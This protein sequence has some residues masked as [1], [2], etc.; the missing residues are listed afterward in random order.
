MKK[1]NIIF[2]LLILILAAFPLVV[3]DQYF[4]HIGILILYTALIS[5]AWNILSGFSGQFSFGHAA[6]FGT[7]AYVSSILLT[8]FGITPWLG[9]FVGAIVAA[10]IGLFIGFLSFRYKLRGVFFALGTLAFA[11]I[12]RIIVQNFAFFNKTLGILIPLNPNPLMFQF[13][14]RV[15]YYYTILIFTLLVSLLVHWIS[16][17]RLGYNLIAIR[18]NEDAA[19]SL[20]VN[21]YKNKMIAIA[22]S[23]AVTAIGGTFYAQYILFIEPPTTFGNDV[24]INIILPTIIGGAGTVLGPIVGSFILIPIGE[25]TTALFGN[26]VG[27]N[28][29]A[30]G[31]ILILVILYLPEGIVGWFQSRF[32]KH[33]EKKKAT[34]ETQHFGGG[35]KVGTYKN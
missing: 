24:S 13:G 33:K 1:S 20:G 25:I 7:G 10:L 34:T 21:T 17:S 14:S 27:L 22:L 29:M 28:L 11:E 23:S 30:Y 9:M 31:V 16:R 2:L 32:N 35:E 8:K 3:K 5:Q 12:L 19:Q 18:E 6:F 4:M 15:G 26:F